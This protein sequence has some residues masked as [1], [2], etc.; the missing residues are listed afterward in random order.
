MANR[1][2]K[3]AVWL[4]PGRSQLAVQF[5]QRTPRAALRCRW[6]RSLDPSCF[7]SF[8]GFV[9][10]PLVL[11]PP[12]PPSARKSGILEPVY[13]RE[14]IPRTFV[15]YTVKRGHIPLDD[16]MT[17]VASPNDYRMLF[18]CEAPGN[19]TGGRDR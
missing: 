7:V 10:F 14:N 6:H 17:I 5:F 2:T 16:T 9:S 15:Y 19:P 11:A 18:G 4:G 1:A 13:Y 12:P 8:L 3:T